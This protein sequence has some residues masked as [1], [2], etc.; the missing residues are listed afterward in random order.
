MSI[1]EAGLLNPLTNQFKRTKDAEFAKVFS[2]I[3]GAIPQENR[4]GRMA[5]GDGMPG[6]AVTIY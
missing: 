4:S 2:N 1:A 6:D 5:K 3:A